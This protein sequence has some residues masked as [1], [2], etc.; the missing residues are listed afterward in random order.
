MICF[1][2]RIVCLLFCA[3]CMHFVGV[4]SLTSWRGPPWRVIRRAPAFTSS[5]PPPCP[6]LLFH[7]FGV[8]VLTSGTG[9]W[10]VKS[11]VLRRFIWEVVVLGMLHGFVCLLWKWRHLSGDGQSLLLE[12][13]L[14]WDMLWLG[15]VCRRPMK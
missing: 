9:N 12:A 14:L 15:R 8:F 11:A 6:G 10:C 3:W 5:P 1:V 7:V 2:W 4:T 13:W